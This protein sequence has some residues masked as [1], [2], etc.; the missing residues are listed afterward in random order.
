MRKIIWGALVA[1]SACLI[2]ASLRKWIA[3]DLTEV[4]GFVTGAV[5]VLLVIEQNI[6]NF[7]VGI[8]NNVFFAALF[9]SSR[10]YGDMA[11]QI[12]Y[13]VLGVA[14][15]WQWLHGGKNRGRLNISH[16]SVRE[17]VILAVAGIAATVAMREYFLRINDSA[18]FLDALT[19]TLSLI[20][21]YL[22]NCKRIENWF[23]WIV[24]DVLYVWLYIQ[25]D[26]HLTAILYAVF[27]FMCLAGLFSWFKELKKQREG[28][29]V[30]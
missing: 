21:Q 22:L 11:L 4:M 5:C 25:K 10:L 18:P 3:I 29:T 12:V 7:P 27:I 9:L 1:A 28:G 15:W 8:L 14:G 19:T 20:A 30:V 6:W 26:L 13:M 24:A 2:A 23:V 17:A 16:T